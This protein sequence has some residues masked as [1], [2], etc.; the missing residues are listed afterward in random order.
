MEK[1]LV[2][3]A[4]GYIALHC[5]VELLK[6]GYGVRGSLRDMSRDNEVAEAVKQKVSNINLSFCNLDL[7]NDEGWD[8]AAKDCDYIL[9]L[10][11]PFVLK[12]PNDENELISPAEQGTL[13][14]MKTAKKNSIK[15]IVLIS[16]MAT[17]AYSDKNK[18]IYNENDW[19]NIN[20]DIGAYR[21]SKTIAEKVAWEFIENHPSNDLKLTTILPGFVFGP[22]LNNDKDS[23]S[24]NMMKKIMNGENEG[25]PEYLSVADVR[26]IAKLMVRSISSRE[27]DGRRLLATSPK[28]FHISKIS[29]IL[30][31][32]GYEIPSYESMKI[33]TAEGGYNSDISPVLSIFDWKQTSLE[34]TVIDMAKKINIYK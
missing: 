8:N 20:L 5:I 25:L 18:N 27:S 7:M 4:S 17:V 15:K 26:D 12:A 10:A 14:V 9:H 11:S 24:V 1:V 16:S 19:S 23:T 32:N 29:Q 33:E 21:K 3:G 13:R 31:K 22:T 2:T 34:E 30:N 6:N 28:S